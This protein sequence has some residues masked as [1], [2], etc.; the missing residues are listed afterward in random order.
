MRTRHTRAIAAVAA[1]APLVTAGAAYAAG[2]AFTAPV[3]GTTYIKKADA[4]S[5]VPAGTATDVAV[6]DAGGTTEVVPV[7]DHADG[8]GIHLPSPSYY[9][10]V[11]ALGLPC[12]GYAAV[13]REI[14]WVIPGLV[15]LLFGCIGALARLTREAAPVV[16]RVP[17]PRVGRR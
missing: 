8:H 7:D 10:L 13:F 9:P 16:A 14:W 1:V 6:A 17:T 4:T 11:L 15:F 3:T 5:A 2:I 12:L